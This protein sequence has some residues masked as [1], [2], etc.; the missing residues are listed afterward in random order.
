MKKEQFYEDA[1]RHGFNCFVEFDNVFSLWITAIIT[2][3]PRI[4]V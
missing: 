3:L 4:I 2:S 1:R